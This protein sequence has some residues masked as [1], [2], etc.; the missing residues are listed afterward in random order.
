MTDIGNPN[1]GEHRPHLKVLST[2]EEKGNESDSQVN[3]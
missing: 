1:T 3:I 2:G